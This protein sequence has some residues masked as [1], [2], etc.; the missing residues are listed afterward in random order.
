MNQPYS[1]LQFRKAL[2]ALLDGTITSEEFARLE[3]AMENAPKLRQYYYDFM[4][5][6]ASLKNRS[7]VSAT[8]LPETAEEE[9]LSVCDALFWQVL[10]EQERQAETV[11]L[12]V[13]D[14]GPELI[15]G[16]REKKRQIRAARRVSRAALYTTLVGWAALFL[17]IGYVI[18]NPRHVTLPTATIIETV[19]PRWQD[20]GFTGH[21]GMRLYNTDAL[22][23]LREGLVKIR[24]DDGAEVLIQSPARFRA[25]GTNQLYL[26]FGKLRSTVPPS[27]LG[28][29][30]R[31]PAAT[32]V[33]YGTE[34]GV[35][36]ER[37]GRTEAHVFKGKVQLRS[38]PDTIRHGGVLQLVSGLSGT[39]TD[40]GQ[41]DGSPRPAE[42]SLFI[43]DLSSVNQA[44]LAGRRF[45]LADVVGG[46]NGFGSGTPDAGIDMQTGQVRRELEAYVQNAPHRFIATPLF[47]FIDGIFMPGGQGRSTQVSSTYLVCDQFEVTSG[48]FWGYLFNGAWHEGTDAPRHPLVLDD[49][50][51]DCS[52]IQAIT[53]H[54]NMGVT[55]DLQQI[56]RALPGLGLTRFRSTAGISQTVAD[57]FD[58]D[59]VVEFW[60]LVD[61]QVRAHQ[62]VRMSDG[63]FEMDVPLDL[64]ARFLSLAVT[65]SD[66]SISSD[67]AVLVNPHLVLDER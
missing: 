44:L 15:T 65:E 9:S 12:E 14:A 66:G 6:H 36:V 3:T 29:V 34:F 25:E 1:H 42:E 63:G 21:V 28:F 33:D 32:I 48:N 18:V 58:R 26:D 20:R 35:L 51:L 40:Q 30:V 52:S 56:R 62:R 47:A 49:V 60:V 64:S 7:G 23:Y 24:L 43:R 53:I 55:F 67:W 13:E 31:T 16:V 59:P 57:Y 61:G 4:L 5:V 10:A 8:S 2:L 38:G 19:A 45:D 37:T 11:H 27:A 50:T 41:F 39:V 17:V 22:L 54:S 46:G